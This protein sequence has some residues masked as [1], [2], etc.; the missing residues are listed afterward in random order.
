M[1]DMHEKNVSA[2]LEQDVMDAYAGVQHGDNNS[3]LPPIFPNASNQEL[4]DYMV[5]ALSRRLN[6]E[7]AFKGGYMLNQLLGNASRMTR[8]VDFSIHNQDD[9]E[10]VKRVLAEIAENFKREGII[11]DYKMKDTIKQ[12]MSG[13]IDFYGFDGRKILGV[14]VGLHD[15]H[16]GIK[17]YQLDVAVVEGFEIERMLCDKLIAVLSR[18]RFRRTK[19][20]YDFFA[21]TS[22]F[23]FD[24]QKLQEYIA[25]RGNAE[26]D[27]IPFSDTAAVAYKKAWERL[28]LR[29]FITGE[30]LHKPDFDSVIQRF[31]KIA[32]P[33]KAGIKFQYWNHHTFELR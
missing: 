3:D 27:N 13:G 2:H 23:D 28:V 9:Y 33:L 31:Y 6:V 15:I 20:L 29:S 18:K 10:S 12:T 8:D 21:I 26:W 1:K 11:N 14:D 19:D 4:L 16:W 25:R 7:K 22:S 17:Q 5:L 32:I 24:Y 30:D